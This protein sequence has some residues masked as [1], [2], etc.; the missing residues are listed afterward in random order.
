MKCECMHERMLVWVCFNESTSAWGD[1]VPE[2]ERKCRGVGRS[3]TN[4][5]A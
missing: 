5:C 1:G 3:E 2:Y 4:V